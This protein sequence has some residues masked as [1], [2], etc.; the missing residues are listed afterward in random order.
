MNHRSLLAAF[1][2]LVLLSAVA[3]AEVVPGSA[4]DFFTR[5]LAALEAGENQTAI[6]EFTKAI[7]L[8][9]DYS[10][11]YFNRGLAYL[12]N[13]DYDFAISDFSWLITRTPEDP[14]FLFWRATAYY[15]LKNYKSALVDV[16]S[17]LDN[18]KNHALAWGLKGDISFDKGDFQAAVAS[19]DRA[20]A[21]MG[22]DLDYSIKRIRA[23]LYSGSYDEAVRSCNVVLKNM[24]EY[25][26][27][28]YY[29]G[30]ANKGLGEF[31]KAEEDYD[32]G[33]LHDVW[34]E[35]PEVLFRRGLCRLLDCRFDAAIA[36]FR[37]AVSTTS[38]DKPRYLLHLILALFYLDRKAEILQLVRD[39]PAVLKPIVGDTA[40]DE[41]WA[42]ILGYC[43]ADI[44]E[45]TLVE[46]ITK[47]IED[48][49]FCGY[50]WYAIATRNLAYGRS[51]RALDAFH[52]VTDMGERQAP[53][54]L[55]AKIFYSLLNNGKISCPPTPKAQT[56]PGKEGSE[57]DESQTK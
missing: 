27:A 44:E 49:V 57:K 55:Q 56:E 41:L 52:N 24:P 1:S 51:E 28:Y 4:E 53:E 40:F 29:R 11:A 7:D 45:T 21:L 15:Y 48:R 42:P 22:F 31:A 13:G 23:L 46:L 16:D 33:L 9:S 36:D 38:K 12:R 10:D 54:Y 26:D 20:L 8:K 39:A 17:A 47:K 6:E 35:N 37:T 2:L 43:V 18:D 14:R 32:Q 25:A 50:A 30:D 3:L 34:K 19:Y 5:G